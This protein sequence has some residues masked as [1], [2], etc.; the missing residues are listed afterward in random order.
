MSLSR[1][2]RAP[3]LS[4]FIRRQRYHIALPHISR[5][6]LDIGCGNADLVN[7]VPTFERYVGIDR[8]P[9]M[10]ERARATFPH[11]EFYQINLELEPLP[12]RL[13]EQKFNTI[14]MLALLEHLS[15]PETVIAKV[16]DLLLPGGRI[17]ATTPTR[18]GHK[19]H[20][21]GSKLGLFYREAA[22]EHQ[23][24]FTRLTLIQLFKSAGL[25]V[26]CYRTFE[27]GCNQL[28]VGAKR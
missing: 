13:R 2:R 16:S 5:N 17:V 22:A 26:S 10:I 7:I 14:T 18:V 27:Y 6:V 12:E 24:I 25:E 23:T 20:R 1:K 15:Q 3:L 8:H 4:Q 28:V 19:I 9:V 21:L 11:H